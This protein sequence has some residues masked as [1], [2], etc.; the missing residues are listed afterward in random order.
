[1]NLLD[2]IQAVRNKTY[3]LPYSIVW[4]GIY[5]RLSLYINGIKPNYWIRQD[6]F[7]RYPKRRED[8]IAV[9]YEEIYQND[10]FS[11]YPHDSISQLEFRKSIAAVDDMKSICDKFFEQSKSIIFQ[12]NNFTVNTDDIKLKEW[13]DNVKIDGFEFYEWVKNVLYNRMFVDPNA[14]LCVIEDHKAEL[15]PSEYAMPKPYI[16]GNE[17]VYYAGYG[18]FVSDTYAIDVMQQIL[19]DKFD[20]AT[21][22]TYPHSMNELPCMQLGGKY[23]RPFVWNSF[24]QSFVGIANTYIQ[25]KSDSVIAKKT[26]APRL[27]LIESQCEDCNSKGTLDT[28]EGPV[29]CKACK[30]TG[31]RIVMNLGDIVAIPEAKAVLDEKLA[32]LDRFKYVTPDPAY[33]NLLTTDADKEFTRAEKALFLFRKETAASESANNLDKQFEEKKI[34]FQAVSERLYHLM[35][36]TLTWVSMYLNYNNGNPK[37]SVFTIDKPISFDLASAEDLMLQF[38]AERKNGLPNVITNNSQLNYLKKVEGDNS[39][40]LKKVKFLQLYDTLYGVSN[41]PLQGYD[42]LTVITHNYLAQLL[43]LYIIKVGE[44]RFLDDT[45]ETTYNALLPELEKKVPA[46]NPFLDNVQ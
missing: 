8:P 35:Y 22:I 37:P 2:I 27:Q 7:Y 6:D 25:E 30:G 16:V 1:M 44:A 40:I 18:H 13:I 12:G 23:L 5:L 4:R 15:L 3:T 32:Q 10:I 20:P 19:H 9:P 24:I 45:Y 28:V 39:I 14:W 17:N 41:I 36:Q 43:E 29:P 26:L 42:P 34:F 21:F 11:R 33:I 46:S 31:K 38:E